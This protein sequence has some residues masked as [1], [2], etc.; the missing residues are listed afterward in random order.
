[1]FNKSMFLIN[2]RY[3]HSYRYIS[4]Y[5]YICNYE[6]SDDY[7]LDYGCNC[8]LRVVSVIRIRVVVVMVI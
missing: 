3:I 1:M 8:I 7:K 5:G 2:Y 4:D 6:Y